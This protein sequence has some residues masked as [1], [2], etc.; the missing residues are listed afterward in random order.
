LIRGYQQIREF[1]KDDLTHNDPFK[2]LGEWVSFLTRDLY[3]VSFVHPTEGEA[4]RVFEVINTRGL[5]LTSADLLK[6]FILSHSKENDRGGIYNRWTKV[7]RDIDSV[8]SSLLVP[9]IRSILTLHAGYLPPKDVYDYVSGASPL[10]KKIPP[11]PPGELVELLERWLPHYLSLADPVDEGGLGTSAFRPIYSAL[12][13]LGVNSVRPLAMAIAGAEN[14]EEGLRELLKIVVRRLVQGYFGTNAMERRIGDAARDVYRTQ[15]WESALEGF[16]ELVPDE[17]EF[18]VSVSRR[19]YSPN[20]LAFLHRSIA[21]KSITPVGA[22]NPYLVRVSNTRAWK[23]F[24]S[25]DF[26]TW[27]KTLGNSVIADIERRPPNTNTWDGFQRQI[28]PSVVPGIAKSF[29][30]SQSSWTVNQVIELGKMLG[31][32]AAKIWYSK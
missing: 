6:N 22:D 21:Q 2:R 14:S 31:D 17:E 32:E 12:N 10:A 24:D 5:E 29:I 3:L 18:K 4:F 15:T 16:K 27:G 23:D 11:P 13:D 9:Y 25:D 7:A 20:M 30:E 26:S 1:V 19:N 8:S 28:L